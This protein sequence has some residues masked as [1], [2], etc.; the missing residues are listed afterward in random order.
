MSVVEKNSRSS[1]VKYSEVGIN[2]IKTGANYN[3]ALYGTFLAGLILGA[4]TFNNAYLIMVSFAYGV[5]K[6]FGY[7][8]PCK[9][10]AI[11]MFMGAVSAQ[12]NQYKATF[13]F[14]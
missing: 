11:M 4:V 8:K 3:G 9:E 5:T 14:A 7:D 13:F 2:R 12:K 6:S 10:A 1:C